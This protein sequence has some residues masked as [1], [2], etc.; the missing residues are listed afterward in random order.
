MTHE[1]K[2]PISTIN[3]ASDVLISQ[4]TDIPDRFSHYLRIIKQENNRLNQQVENVLRAARI[5]KGKTI[6]EME[7]IDLHE[8][9]QN[10]FSENDLS[11]NQK[12]VKTHLN[13]EAEKSVILADRLHLT[14]ILFNLT[15]NAIKYN[16]NNV[17]IIVATK[18]LK[19]NIELRIQDN[20]I[21]ILPVH[22]KQVF[23]KFYRVPTG[24]LHEV[25]GFGLGLFYVKQVCEAQHWKI[26]IESDIDKGTVIV[27]IIPLV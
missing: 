26:S 2:T 19:N 24:N 21:G 17:E 15:D 6:M 9:L 18:N 10:V 14:N 7:K 20:G 16:S 3:I 22:Q 1:F 23:K 5:E 8:I 27:L 25:K 4:L 13:F 12:N 11:S